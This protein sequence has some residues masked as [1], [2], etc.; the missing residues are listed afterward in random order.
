LTSVKLK[1]LKLFLGLKRE[2][3]LF[4]SI[5]VTPT[6]SLSRDVDAVFNWLQLDKK[7]SDQGIKSRE[8]EFVPRLYPEHW[9]QLQNVYAVELLFL[10]VKRAVYSCELR[11]T[12]NAKDVLAGYALQGMGS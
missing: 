1:S 6:P 7:L 12:D 9:H 8:L 2:D 3:H 4:W 10:S 11:F 5:R